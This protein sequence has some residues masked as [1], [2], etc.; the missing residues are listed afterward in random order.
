MQPLFDPSDFRLP[1]GIAHVCAGGETA[2][3]RAHDEAL[4][5]YVADKSRGM[6]G[7]DAQD[8]QI[9]AARAGIGRLWGV[10]HGDIG[11]VGNVAEGMS[12]LV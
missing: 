2:A 11:F 3:L 10:D 1:P 7:R 6:A 4:L 5:R 12:M 8:G 9:E